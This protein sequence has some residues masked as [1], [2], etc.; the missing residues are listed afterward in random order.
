MPKKYLQHIFVGLFT[1]KIFD[2]CRLN[3]LSLAKMVTLS[4]KFQYSDVIFL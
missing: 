4:L 2:L 1:K 3:S